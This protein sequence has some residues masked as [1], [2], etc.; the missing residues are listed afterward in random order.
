MTGE[1]NIE[2]KG[3]RFFAYHGL[4]AEER[5][6]G[7]EFEVN[8]CVSFIPSGGTITDLEETVDY[9]A[10]YDLLKTEMQKPR[11]LLETLVMEVSELIHTRFSLIK[12]TE[13]AVTKIHLPIPGFT[14]NVTV[15]NK[16]TS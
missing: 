7:N 10:L 13:I 8:L 15:R 11:D 2:L 12:K 6:T 9:C 1:I 4:Y 5:K 16:K 14:G 3:L